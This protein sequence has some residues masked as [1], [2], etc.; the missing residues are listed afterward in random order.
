MREM[1]Q[2]HGTC[3]MLA[4]EREEV[5]GQVRFFPLRVAQCI[6]Q[7]SVKGQPAVQSALEFEPDTGTLWVQCIMTSRPFVGPEAGTLGERDW[8]SKKDAGARRGVGLRLVQGLVEWARGHHWQRT[9]K[10]TNA[11]LDCFYGQTGG[12]GKGFWEKA[13]FRVVGTHYREYKRDDEWKSTVESQAKAKGMSK[14]EAWTTYQM[15]IDIR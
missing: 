8:P 13:G 7:A 11:D 12:A 15:A 6:A 1:I 5:V 10:H 9:V 4:W 2:R 14:E 3:A